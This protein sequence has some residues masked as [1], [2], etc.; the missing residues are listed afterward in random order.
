MRNKY[1]GEDLR[2]RLE[3]S[4]LRY[5][6]MPYFCAVN[7]ENLELRDIPTGDLRH[8]VEPDDF[9][10]DISSVPLGYMN[11]KHYNCAIYL[12]RHPFRKYKQGVVLELLT[13][14]PLTP[15]RIAIAPHRLRCAGLV[16]SINGEFP[17][18]TTALRVLADG[19]HS[20]ALSRDIA[21]MRDGAEI[22]VF[23]KEDHIGSFP[24]KDGAKAVV[25]GA[26]IEFSW[27]L[28]D[29]LTEVGLTLVETARE[30]IIS[31]V[32]RW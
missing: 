19:A 4:I 17:S 18:L 3:N 32:V 1:K 22:K 9:L 28:T 20:V 13:N 6:K 26:N 31:D 12:K 8:T 16:N 23:I 10:L 14:T 25:Y 21:F 29:I 7:G 24:I 30:P 15:K 2:S 27:A 11:S 5:N